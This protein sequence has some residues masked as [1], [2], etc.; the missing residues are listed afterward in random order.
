MK[1]E[2]GPGASEYAPKGDADSPP[3]KRTLDQALP[4]TLQARIT[5]QTVPALLG[6]LPGTISE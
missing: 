6:R 2:S 1:S 3:G 5:I 4:N